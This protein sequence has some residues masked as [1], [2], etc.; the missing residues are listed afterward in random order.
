MTNTEHQQDPA[1]LQRIMLELQTLSTQVGVKGLL[2]HRT[3]H[4]VEKVGKVEA[5]HCDTGR[6]GTTA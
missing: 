6:Q 3:Y 4:G 1:T 2:K 5:R